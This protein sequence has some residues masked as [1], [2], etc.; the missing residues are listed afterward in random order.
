MPYQ[1]DLDPG[2][3]ILRLRYIGQISNELIKKAYKATP[4][5]V[6][7]T[8]PR[9]MIID[10]S[11]VTSFD[12]SIQ[13]IHELADYK[14]TVKDPS[15]PR[16]IVAP[17]TYMFGMSRMFQILGGHKR[18]MLQVVK[19]ANEAYSQLDVTK[20]KFEPLPS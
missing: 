9:A 16:I 2:N 8:N 3:K 19:S 6:D 7:Q 20:P 12:V 15:V 4:Q 13:T 5:A 11:E 18:P 17:S 14:P 1:F 10:L